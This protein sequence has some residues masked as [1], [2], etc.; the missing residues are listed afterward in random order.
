MTATGV[1]PPDHEPT[2]RGG[3]QIDSRPRVRRDQLGPTLRAW[4]GQPR[5][6]RADR[7]RAAPSGQ[8]GRLTRGPPTRPGGPSKVVRPGPT[9]LS[10]GSR[11]R[12][13]GSERHQPRHRRP[14]ERR[15]DRHRWFVARLPR[16]PGRPRPGRR[17]QGAQPGRRPGRGQAVRPRA[18]GDG[19][20]L[21]PRGH[22][23][24]VL[25]RCHRPRRALPGHAVLPE[26]LAPGPDRH[27]RRSSGRPRSA[28]STSRPRRSPP[29]TT[30]AS[31][32]STSSRPTSC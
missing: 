3:E 26:R 28:T 4:F 27:R 30:R 12:N 16:P 9:T 32:T 11:W 15:A 24:G 23:A 29:P 5:H 25:E 7:N 2:S 10:S 18:Q 21:A 8:M 22:R 20:P 14:R 31:S 13:L 6:H 19:A 17:G 1:R